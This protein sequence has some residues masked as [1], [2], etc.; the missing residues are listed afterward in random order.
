MQKLFSKVFFAPFAEKVKGKKIYCSFSG[1]G[2]SLALLLFLSHWAKE[3][4]F[5]LYA[6]H[7]EH[8]F[9]GEE[10]L[11]DAEFC[12]KKCEEKKIPFTCISLSVPENKLAGEGDEE[13]ARRLRL[14]AWKK[15]IHFPE[16]EYIA[17]GH[18]AGDVAENMFL[19]LFRG[20]NSSS[21]T[22]LRHFSKVED[23]TFFRPLLDCSKQMLEGFLQEQ[24]E[25]F[26]C[27]DSTNKEGVY[28]RNFIRNTLLP[29]IGKNFPFAEKGII[30]SG[31]GV[32]CD[33]LFLEE[34][35]EK[36]YEDWKKKDFSLENLSF[37]H[38]AL[39]IRVLRY[40]LREETGQDL[41][42]DGRMLQRVRK[43]LDKNA[44]KKEKK[45]G[46]SILIPVSGK[47]GTFLLFSSG[48]LFLKNGAE[49]KEEEE[50]SFN[51]T[52]EDFSCKKLLPV[53]G[54][55][56]SFMIQSC[57]KE[58]IVYEKKSFFFD[59][60]LLSFPLSYTFWQGGEKMIPFGRK[61]PLLVKKLFSDGKI[62]AV[63]R[64]SYPLIRESSGNI[65]CMGSF[66]R[67]SL[68]PVTEK[69]KMVLKISFEDI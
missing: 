1:G 16:K 26:W 39:L 11:K 24:N 25:F 63:N 23:L 60:E 59:A 68:A 32:L 21:L 50:N 42:P 14:E 62:S 6:L 30:A 64:N 54:K 20:G 28:K 36:A 18:H 61:K 45:N 52:W 46:E 47:K 7:F 44:V 37:L 65:L 9:R 29:M 13:A 51:Y 8:G 5:T 34:S 2:D 15:I 17:T 3:S 4:H 69:T 67:S 40:F 12:R 41:V 27:V 58:E 66:R 38:D 31:K 22:S 55:D 49:K 57:R 48:K 56:F 10:S 33:A 53:S 43:E 19:R 35:A